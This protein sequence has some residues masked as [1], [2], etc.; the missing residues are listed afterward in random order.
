MPSAIGK[1]FG[2]TAGSEFVEWSLCLSSGA[3]NNA[4]SGNI[5][6]QSGSISFWGVQLEIGGQATPLEKPDPR[7]DLSNC[8]RFFLA[9][10]IYVG[11]SG[12]YATTFSFPST[13]RAIPTVAGG[14]AGYAAVGLDAHAI[15]HVQTANSSQNMTFSAEL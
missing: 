14:G 10:S 5:G 12:L 7:Y 3:N 6:V 4:Y 8:Q 1:T 15:T 2:T 13:M 11:P 9:A